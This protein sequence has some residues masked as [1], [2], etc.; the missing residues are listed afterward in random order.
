MKRLWR[1]TLIAA[2]ILAVIAIAL[3]ATLRNHALYGVFALTRQ[4][5]N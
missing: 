4:T 3:L 1:I 5:N 2:A